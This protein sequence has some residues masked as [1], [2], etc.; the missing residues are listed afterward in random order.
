ARTAELETSNSE[1]AQA[2]AGLQAA[3][4]QL[5]QTEKMASLGLLVSGVAHELNNP[6]SFILG[7]VEP[8]QKALRLLQTRA[9]R[10]ADV[11][12]AAEVR[13]VTKIFELMALGAERTAAIVNDLRVFSRLG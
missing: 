5:L 3:Q 12:L 6:L 4:A 8:L 11:E 10:H 9:T 1:L 13:R 2:Y 7:N